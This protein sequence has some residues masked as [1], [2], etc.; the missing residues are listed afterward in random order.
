MKLHLIN[1]S[2][3]SVGKTSLFFVPQVFQ[4]SILTN[5]QLQGALITRTQPQARRRNSTIPWLEWAQAIEKC[6]PAILQLS[7]GTRPG[8]SHLVFPV[9][10]EVDCTQVWHSLTA[11]VVVNGLECVRVRAFGGTPVGGLRVDR[12]RAGGQERE[13]SRRRSSS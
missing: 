5:F 1:S 6:P 12:R 9:M 10:S 11:A 3:G 4:E 13:S 8:S 7:L 2:S